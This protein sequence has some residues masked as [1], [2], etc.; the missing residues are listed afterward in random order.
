M[1]SF[2]QGWWHEQATESRKSI[3]ETE[4]SFQSGDEEGP[5]RGKEF[6][7]HLYD[8]VGQ[9]RQ[10]CLGGAW[11][12]GIKTGGREEQGGNTAIMQ[13]R[14]DET[15]SYLWAGGA[16]RKIIWRIFRYGIIRFPS[17]VV[18]ICETPGDLRSVTERIWS[19]TE[20]MTETL[21]RMKH[22]RSMQR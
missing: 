12:S 20:M 8:T 13:M 16:E 9:W 10:G 19:S 7:I 1:V 15:L 14:D 4:G 5:E 22:P 18:G 2:I 11:I 17:L 21:R 6:G 3:S